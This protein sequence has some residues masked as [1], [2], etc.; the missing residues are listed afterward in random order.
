MVSNGC[1]EAFPA[2]S[3]RKYIELTLL[4]VD[5]LNAWVNRFPLISKV[6]V[7]GPGLYKKF[8]YPSNLAAIVEFVTNFITEAVVLALLNTLTFVRPATSDV[9]EPLVPLPEPEY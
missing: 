5:R 2:L 6:P 4:E 9:P 1:H 3:P 8:P 7:E